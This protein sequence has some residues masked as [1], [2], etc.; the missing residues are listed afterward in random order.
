MPY[1]YSL[2]LALY[3]KLV[4]MATFG[5]GLF[6]AIISAI[7]LYSILHV[8]LSDVTYTIL[9]PIMWSALEPCLAITLACIP[10]LRPLLGGRYTPTGTAKLGPPTMKSRAVTQKR[11]RRFK[12]LED[13]VCITGQADDGPQQRPESIRYDAISRHSHVDANTDTDVELSAIPSK[14]D[15]RVEERQ[16]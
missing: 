3:K 7:R 13:E 10:L 14:K 16:L 1:I 9:M 2:E 6:V 4:L 11:S 8:D 15:W 12:I 5:L